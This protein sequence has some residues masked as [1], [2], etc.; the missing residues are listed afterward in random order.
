[1]TTD[2]DGFSLTVSLPAAELGALRRRVTYLEATLVQVLR[3]QRGIKEWFTA[4][5]L[6]ELRLPG[7]SL[8]KGAITRQAR[9]QGWTTR[10]G[11][12][13]EYHFSTLPRRTFEALIDRVIAPATPEDP[14]NQVPAFAPPPLP[15]EAPETDTAPPWLLP[16]MRVIRSEAPATVNEAM[17]LLPRYLPKGVSCP[18]LEE[19]TVALRRLGMV[20]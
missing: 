20:G 11:G 15:P 4:A 7:L 5:E 8:G 14:G 17:E 16:L 6:A 12:R 18:T 3:G 2:K 13:N 19:A 9:Q 10:P 1:M